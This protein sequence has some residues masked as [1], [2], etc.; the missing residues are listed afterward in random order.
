MGEKVGLSPVAVI[1]SLMVGAKLLGVVGMLIAVPAAAVLNVFI[2]EALE[3][4]RHSEML[5]T[6]NSNSINSSA[7]EEKT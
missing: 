1:F 7:I 4:Y 3:R 5:Q 6:D 2:V